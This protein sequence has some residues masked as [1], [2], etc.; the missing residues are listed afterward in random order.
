MTTKTKP[1]GAAPPEIELVYERIGNSHVFTA[2]TVGGFYYGSSS[3]EK[4]FNEAAHALSL[5]ISRMYKVDAR[6]S[7]GSSLSAFEDHLASDEDDPSELL[8]K[9][10]VIAKK[11]AEKNDYSKK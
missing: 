7:L 3:L 9:N 4:T 5:H 6:Y 10:V 8:I 1:L 2:P 11:S